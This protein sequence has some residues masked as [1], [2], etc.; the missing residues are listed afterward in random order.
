MRLDPK[1]NVALLLERSL[2]AKDRVAS[3]P[4]LSRSRAQRWTPSFWL[5][6]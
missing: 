1:Q 3:A 2:D 6:D 4:S 5:L